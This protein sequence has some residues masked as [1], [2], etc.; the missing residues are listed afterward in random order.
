MLEFL[1]MF[2]WS[3]FS[4]EVRMTVSFLDILCNSRRSS[5]LLDY[6]ND[7]VSQE[8]MEDKRPVVYYGEQ[9]KY[10]PDG[11]VQIGLLEE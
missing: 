9:D 6:V 8:G 10:S 5:S 1:K 3:M 2:I 11:V 4:S 7:D